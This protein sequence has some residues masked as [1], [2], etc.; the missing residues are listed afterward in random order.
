[1]Y[2]CS[3]WERK[4]RRKENSHPLAYSPNA[5]SS[6]ELPGLKL[7]LN[8]GLLQ[9]W[10][11]SSCLNY[12]HYFPG[13]GSAGERVGLESGIKPRY[14]ETQDSGFP[15]DILIYAKCLS[16]PGAFLTILS[17]FPPFLWKKLSDSLLAFGTEESL[18]PLVDRHASS[19]LSWA[20]GF[21]W[22]HWLC[23]WSHVQIKAVFIVC[24]CELCALVPLR[25]TC[26]LL[27]KL[28]CM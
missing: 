27:L 7:K 5:F 22:G 4:Q 24:S 11:E 12:Q 8:P 16:H 6:W 3:V 20:S 19:W 9:G 23:R 14:P 2:I 15:A 28:I 18:E 25:V 26:M 1:M 21:P 13:S 10:Q 17:S